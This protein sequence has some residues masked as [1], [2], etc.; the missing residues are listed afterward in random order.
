MNVPLFV[1]EF[2]L[3]ARLKEEATKLFSNPNA[4]KE[5]KTAITKRI[6]D[7][8]AQRE[9]NR[10]ASTERAAE[11]SWEEWWNNYMQYN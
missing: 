9:Q 5:D 10:I 11:A 4:S 3:D 1:Q 6:M 2:T 8:Q 7:M